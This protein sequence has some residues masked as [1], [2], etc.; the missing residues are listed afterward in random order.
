MDNYGVAA[1]VSWGP[2]ID[3]LT[4]LPHTGRADTIILGHLQCKVETILLLNI[5]I[6]FRSV[7]SD[8]GFGSG[9][10]GARYDHKS[11]NMRLQFVILPHTLGFT[12]CDSWP[13]QIHNPEPRASS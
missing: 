4:T 7:C 6:V 8:G 3:C 12:H 13:S 1:L 2:K 11:R 5:Y 10:L 9:N